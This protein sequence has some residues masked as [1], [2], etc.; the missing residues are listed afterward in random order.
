MTVMGLGSERSNNLFSVSRLVHWRINSCI[1]IIYPRACTFIRWTTPPI[2]YSCLRNRT[3]YLRHGIIVT[4]PTTVT[5][6]LA[7]QRRGHTWASGLFRHE[8]SSLHTLT[9]I[10]MQTPGLWK[11]FYLFLWRR[12]RQTLNR[13]PD[14]HWS[15]PFPLSILKV[16]GQG[17]RLSSSLQRSSILSGRT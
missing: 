1:Q 7:R 2:R 11:L 17:Y 15:I 9:F 5:Q 3:A 6:G 14:P 12:Q 13:N 10:W 16:V 4:E 8:F